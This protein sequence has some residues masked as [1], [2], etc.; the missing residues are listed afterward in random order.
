MAPHPSLLRRVLPVAALLLAVFAPLAAQERG[1]IVGRATDVQSGEGLAAVQ[2]VARGIQGSVLTGTTTRSDGAFTLQPL[3]AGEYTV[4]AQR[5]GYAKSN[6]TRVV[7]REG[8]ATTV[9]MALSSIATQGQAIVVT[10]ARR[11]ERAIDAPVSIAVVEGETIAE[12]QEPTVFGALKAVPGVDYFETGL[13]QQQIS[14][15]GFVSPF[16]SDVLLLIDNRLSS[17]PGVAKPIA[18][19][20]LATQNDI[21]QVEVVLG[22]ASALYGAGAASGVVNVITKDPREYPGQSVQITV[23][24]HDLFRVGVRSAGMLGENFGY[25]LSGERYTARDFETSNQFVVRNDSGRTLFSIADT[26]VARPQINDEAISGSL[27]FYPASGA[28]VVYSGG[29]TRATF[30]NLSNIGRLQG[31]GWDIYYHQLRANIDNVLGLGSLFIQGYYTGNSAG[32]TYNIDAATQDRI[33]TA[34]GGPGLTRGDAIARETF[35]D[36]SSRIDFEIQHGVSFNG[37]QHLTTG[38][39]WRRSRPNSEGTYLSDGPGLPSIRVDE[40]AA[41]AQYENEMVPHLR[42]ILAGRADHNTDYGSFVSPKAGVTYTTGDRSWRLTY[43]R[44][45]D[46]PPLQVEHALSV[47]STNYAG[48]HLPLILRGAY[49]GFQFVNIAGGAP[50]P[51]IGPLKPVDITSIEAGFKGAVFGSLVADATIY[52]SRFKNF[53]A[54]PLPINDPAH[55]I[56]V[57]DGNGGARRE[58]TLT[59]FNYGELGVWGGDLGLQLPLTRMVALSG[60]ASYERPD[61]EFKNGRAGVAKPS[62]NAPLHKYHAGITADGWWRPGS[63]AELN[64]SHVSRFDFV[65]A[66]AYGTGP[67]PTYDVV[68]VNAGIPLPMLT[69]ASVRAGIA[70]KNLLDKR[71]VELPGAPVLGRVLMATFSTDYR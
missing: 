53:I 45:F 37:T 39:Q 43:N 16:T 35:I 38:V 31:D 1:R 69:F 61:D 40:T 44:A 33:P 56:F 64:F 7:V 25:K 27:Y 10:G 70:I 17:L 23:G 32:H 51:P 57:A 63:Y 8:E 46:S 55:G 62:F 60:A 2:I 59:Y 26:G 36:K 14:A 54:G 34:F 24:T 22:P 13:A 30:I 4:E 15:R 67:V 21:R 19:L 18:G 6:R 65:A 52:R 48:T 71:H 58:I 41:Y 9:S 20:L 29:L 11:E 12:R 5:I 47:L 49:Q 42:F 3:P 68:D 50:L 28:R 66:Q